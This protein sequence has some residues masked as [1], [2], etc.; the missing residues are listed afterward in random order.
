MVDEL[1]GGRTDAAARSAR[2]RTS[3]PLPSGAPHPR[4]TT[5]APPSHSTRLSRLLDAVVG[6]TSHMPI[7]VR[8]LTGP[9]EAGAN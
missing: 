1:T 9:G 3:R 7:A 8:A 5:A 2:Q 6:A 4:M